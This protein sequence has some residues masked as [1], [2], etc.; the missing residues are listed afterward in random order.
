MDISTLQSLLDSHADVFDKIRQDDMFESESAIDYNYALGVENGFKQAI[1]LI[2]D[3]LE[4][5]LEAR[6]NDAQWIDFVVR[7][8]IENNTFDGHYISWDGAYDEAA[9]ELDVD[10]DTLCDAFDRIKEAV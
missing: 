10:H 6:D 9:E 2:K 8:A 3:A 7:S 1:R 5:E 4:S